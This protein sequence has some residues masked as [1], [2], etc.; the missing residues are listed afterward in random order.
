M[1]QYGISMQRLAR[2]RRSRRVEEIEHGW[3]N[4]TPQY[5]GEVTESLYF[6][7]PG[8]FER[9]A[10]NTLHDDKVTVARME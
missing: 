6:S 5:Q 7:S 8:S 10:H 3:Q 4:I 9:W 1:L 2:M